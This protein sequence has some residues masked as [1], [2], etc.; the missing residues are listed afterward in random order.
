MTD[1]PYM[2][3]LIGVTTSEVRRGELLTQRRVQLAG[4]VGGGVEVRPAR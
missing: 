1:I 3:P 2:A 4:A